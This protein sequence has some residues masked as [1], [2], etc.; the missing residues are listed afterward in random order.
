[1]IGI[2]LAYQ[3]Y[4]SNNFNGF[5]RSETN[6]KVS[7]FKRDKKSGNPVSG[8]CKIVDITNGEEVLADKVKT[9]TD[10]CKEVIGNEEETVVEEID[11]I[12]AGNYINIYIKYLKFKGIKSLK[13]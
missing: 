12:I 5:I 6:L 13:L 3:F 10:K 2:Y 4:Q 11:K 8:K 1:M 7:E 9:V